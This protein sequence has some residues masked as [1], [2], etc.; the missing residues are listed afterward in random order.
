MAYQDNA[1]DTFFSVDNPTSTEAD[2]SVIF[3]VPF[4]DNAAEVEVTTEENS[5][6]FNP[7][8][9]SV[10]DQIDRIPDDTFVED[11]DK[12]KQELRELLNDINSRCSRRREMFP[13]KH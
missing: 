10:R 3:A 11:P 13:H 9:R 5:V 6:S 8:T 2:G 4:P 12:H 7:V 1:I